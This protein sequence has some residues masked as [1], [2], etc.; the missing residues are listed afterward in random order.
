[1]P[2]ATH[3]VALGFALVAVA[4]AS[5]TLVACTT[6]GVPEAQVDERSPGAPVAAFYGDSY[7]RGTGASTQ[8]ARWSTIVCE[9]RRW[10]EFNPSID[11]LGYVNNREFLTSDLVDQIVDLEPAPDIVFVTMGLND[12]FSMPARSDEIRAAIDDDLQRFRSEIPDARLIVVEPFWY[13]DERP[14]SLEQLIGWVEEAAARVGAD[15]IEGAS[16]WLEGHEDD[17]MSVDGI[18]PNDEGYAQIAERMLDE[19]DRLGL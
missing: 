7:T 4:C 13:Q 3:R 6:L 5:L 12:T 14:Q 17:W 2:R 10:N 19:L 15:Y 18:H 16:H 11:G 1:V 9:T 8:E